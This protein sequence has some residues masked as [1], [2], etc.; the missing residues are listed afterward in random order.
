MFLRTGFLAALEEMGIEF[1]A[2]AGCSAGAL[3]GGVYVSGTDLHHWM[4]SISN[5]HTREYWTPDS[6]LRFFWNMIVRKGRG[7]S[8]FS[9]TRSAIEFIQS[10][11]EVQRF[12][13]CKI[14]FYSLSMNLSRGAK[15]LFSEGELAARI[16]ASAAMPAVPLG[17]RSRRVVRNAG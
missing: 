16:M 12:E 1:V 17:R 5:A 11:L 4:E 3:V 10:N 8:G 2:V 7:Y 14:P 13:E 9:D 15:T 6:W